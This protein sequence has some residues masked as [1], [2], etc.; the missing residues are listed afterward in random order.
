MA[1]GIIWNKMAGKAELDVKQVRR[2]NPSFA[3]LLDILNNSRLQDGKSRETA[4]RLKQ[5]TVR[6]HIV[7]RPWAQLCYYFVHASGGI[8]VEVYQT[9]LPRAAT[10]LL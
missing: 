3:K 2:E 1:V 10:V 4:S 9:A 6:Q 5:V 7:C 8:Q